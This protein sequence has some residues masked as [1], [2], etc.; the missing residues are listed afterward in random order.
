MFFWFVEMQNMHVLVAMET[1]CWVVRM[2]ECF[3][4]HGYQ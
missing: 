4:M 2:V 3:S 1:Q